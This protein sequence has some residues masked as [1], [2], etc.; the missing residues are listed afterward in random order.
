VIESV[1]FQGKDRKEYP[2]GLKIENF[3]VEREEFDFYH[4][5]AASE[6]DPRLKGRFTETLHIPPHAPALMGIKVIDDRL[7]IITGNRNWK[8]KENEVLVYSL[9]SMKYEGSFFIPFPNL[10]QTQWYDKYYIT[11][12]LIK[13][14]DDYYSSYEIYLVEDRGSS[15]AGS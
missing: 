8:R 10:L 5:Y 1:D 6:T 12:T 3:K 7:F 2:I 14:D 11:R 9:P 15:A 13:K 4:E